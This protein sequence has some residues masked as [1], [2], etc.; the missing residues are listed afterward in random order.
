MSSEVFA[1][2]GLGALILV[3][4][5]LPLLTG[6]LPLSLPTVAVGAGVLGAWAIGVQDRLLPRYNET[7]ETFTNWYW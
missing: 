4:T 2:V 5:W 3:T 1:F 7:A 6:N